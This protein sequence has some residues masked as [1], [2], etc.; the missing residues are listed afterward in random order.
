M[1]SFNHEHVS[2]STT[3]NDR[4]INGCILQK[5]TTKEFIHLQ[6]FQ[7]ASNSLSFT[8]TYQKNLEIRHGDLEGHKFKIASQQTFATTI[9]SHAWNGDLSAVSLPKAVQAT[10]TSTHEFAVD[11][12]IVRHEFTKTHLWLGM[13]LQK[14]SFH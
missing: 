10:Q 9:C 12:L 8:V 6:T 7:V 13:S 3:I 11:S 2:T 1:S 4:V 14:L 5:K